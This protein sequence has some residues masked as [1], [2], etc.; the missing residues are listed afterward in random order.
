LHGRGLN[1]PQLVVAAADGL[2]LVR[3]V[4]PEGKRA[5]GAD[6]YLRGQPGVAGARL[7]E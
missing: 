6:E 2:V 4:Q 1:W 7:G 3:R 5:M